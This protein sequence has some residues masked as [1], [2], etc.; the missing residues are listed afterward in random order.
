MKAKRNLFKF[1]IA[2]LACALIADQA[3]A[4]VTGTEFQALYTWVNGV[5]TGYFGRTIA[6]A[7]VGMGAIIAIAKTNPI[8]ILAGAGFAVFLQYVPTIVTGIMTATA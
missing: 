8:P 7:A 6:V 1:I 4:G 3:L 5:V 2:A